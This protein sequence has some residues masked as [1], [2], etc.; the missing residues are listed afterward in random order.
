MQ[1]YVRRPF[2]NSMDSNYNEIMDTY[3]IEI[4]LYPQSFT[5]EA[6]NKDDAIEKAKGKFYEANGNRSIYAIENVEKIKQ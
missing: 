3:E 4:S 1:C 6:N 5:I 2:W